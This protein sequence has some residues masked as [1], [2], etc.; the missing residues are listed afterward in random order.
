MCLKP[1]PPTPAPPPA[2]GGQQQQP[3]Q[4]QPPAENPPPA[5]GGDTQPSEADRLAGLD[6][7][8]VNGG[9]V[10]SGPRIVLTRDSGGTVRG[11]SAVCT[12]QGC[13][14]AG[15]SN[16]TINCNCHGSKFNPTN[17]AVVTGPATRAL[18]P[19]AVAVQ[20]NAVY[21]A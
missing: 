5:G 19:V 7:V 10:L 2:G 9:L 20:N 3:Q 11:F 8:P 12:H 14:V 1:T 6:Q 18:P 13:I 4:Q 16:G 15:V 21:R 17:G